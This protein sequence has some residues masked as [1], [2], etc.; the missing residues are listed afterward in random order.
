MNLGDAGMARL[1]DITRQRRELF[2]HYLANPIPQV[3][4]YYHSGYDL[5]GNTAKAHPLMA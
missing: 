1:F 2:Y 3:A 4:S 5:S